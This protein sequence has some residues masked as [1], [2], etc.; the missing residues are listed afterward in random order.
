MSSTSI[1]LPV[2][3]GRG[4]V[5]DVPT[6][7]EGFTD[8]FSSRFVD[9]GNDVGD[10]GAQKPLARAYGHAWR[11]PCGIEIVRQTSE[12]WRHDGWFRCPH[13]LQPRLARLNSA[14]RRLPTLLKL[15]GN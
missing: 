9:I 4:S 8:T 10:Q 1:Q 7:P 11:V 6:L 13:R 5:S 3:E 14:K 15:R 12:V 2:A